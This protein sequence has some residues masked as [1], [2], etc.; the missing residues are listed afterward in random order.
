MKRKAYPNYKASGVE[1]LGEVPEHW[2]VK[3]VQFL[4]Q[5]SE[6]GVWGEEPNFNETDTIVLRSTEQTVDGFWKIEEPAL[7]SL[8]NYE[9]RKALLI[10]GDLLVTKA[11][12]SDFHIGKTTIVSTDIE[13]RGCCYSN[14]MQRIRL[15]FSEYPRFVWYFFNNSIVREQFQYYS[16]TTT[17]LQNLNPS[18]IGKVL[19]SLPPSS[20]QQ[21]IVAYLDREVTKIDSL[22]AKKQRLLA[23]LA[24]RR[25]A[26]IS[27]AV[28][29]GLDSKVKM[30]P[31]GVEWL[32]EVPEHWNTIRLK[33]LC[34][35]RYGIG[36]P[37][38]YVED[39][40]P[41]IRATNINEG[42]IETK[43]L[44][45]VDP[46]DIPYSRIVWLKTGD[47]I[48]VRSGAYT[49]DSSIISEEF[50]GSIA[51]FDM[52][53][54]C[55]KVFSKFISYGLLSKYLKDGQ[56]YLQKLRAAQPHLNAEELGE[57][58]VFFPP[59]PEQ[60]SIAAYLD[61]ETAKIDALSA[62]VETIIERLKEYR[63]ALISD[64]VTGKVDLRE[65]V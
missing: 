46:K 57:C 18:L 31:S 54:S 52:I 61:R 33:H 49:G 53:L 28:T 48:V 56:I 5:R 16:N 40:V 30:K 37:P 8:D 35:I 47:I 36:E 43:N 25:T 23:L 44:V 6:G 17:G 7:R 21:S 11:S 12:G 42:K 9:K 65:A 29:K 20:E 45:K 4:S 59:P 1:W 38:E 19:L 41:L 15:N 34:Q 60:R 13:K 64:A 39:G 62:K 58:L 26:L 63:T 3:K 32:G 10:A 55:T 51:G 14:F 50:S 22:I 24:E 27:K 2:G